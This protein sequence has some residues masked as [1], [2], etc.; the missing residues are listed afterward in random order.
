[1]RRKDN[2]QFFA[3]KVISKKEMLTKDKEE[4][5]FNERNIMARMKHP[6]IVKL[7]YAFQNVR[8]N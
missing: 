7:H 2:G 6:F 8:K 1:M 4:N 5:V 3:I